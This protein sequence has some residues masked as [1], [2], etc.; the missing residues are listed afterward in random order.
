MTVTVAYGHGKG[1][2]SFLWNWIRTSMDHTEYILAALRA[3]SK[4][5]WAS[6]SEK[7]VLNLRSDW[8]YFWLAQAKWLCSCPSGLAWNRYG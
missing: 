5:L 3:L 2:Q 7:T 8:E 1:V 4:V 6:V